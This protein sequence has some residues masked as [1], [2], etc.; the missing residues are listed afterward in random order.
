MRKDSDVAY[1]AKLAA[2]T[3]HELEY[4]MKIY[5]RDGQALWTSSPYTIP[6]KHREQALE[7]YNVGKSYHT[8]CIADNFEIQ[9]FAIIPIIA[10]GELQGY[11]VSNAPEL[12]IKAMIQLFIKSIFGGNKT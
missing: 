11:A 8:E 10:E 7:C 4:D 2:Y 1:F 5:D 9:T 6:E 12:F 3:F